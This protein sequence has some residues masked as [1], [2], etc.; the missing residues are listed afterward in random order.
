[1]ELKLSEI[2]NELSFATRKA[3]DAR[4]IVAEKILADLRDYLRYHLFREVEKAM[5]TR[6]QA[7]KKRKTDNV[8]NKVVQFL[9]QLLP[10]MVILLLVLSELLVLSL[11]MRKTPTNRRTSC[12]VLAI[13]TSKRWKRKMKKRRK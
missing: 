3:M 13:G 9:L 4:E 7:T 5:I 11:T 1:M 8:E 6:K 2:A 12:E 10:R